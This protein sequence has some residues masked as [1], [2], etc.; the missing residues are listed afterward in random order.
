MMRM[1]MAPT[2]ILRVGRISLLDYLEVKPLPALYPPP[3]GD[4]LFVH[5]NLVFPVPFPTPLDRYRYPPNFHAMVVLEVLAR[6][7][8]AQVIIMRHPRTPI[9]I[10]VPSPSDRLLLLSAH[11][12]GHHLGRQH[13]LQCLRALVRGPPMVCNILPRI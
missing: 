13:A 3:S 6:L 2:R 12:P 9:D 11:M 4:P 7:V 10:P 8:A 5:Q 1:W